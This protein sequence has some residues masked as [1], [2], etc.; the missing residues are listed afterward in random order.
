M[1]RTHTCGEIRK[2]DTG[3]DITLSGWVHRRRDHGGIIF[4]DLR[5]RY[6]LTQIV[7]DPEEN[8]DAHHV[9]ESL[10]SE[11]VIQI[12]G[13]VRP[14]LEG[15]ENSN[16]DTGEV[17]VL[18]SQVNILNKAK[19]PPFEIDQDKDVREDLRLEYRY[20]DLRKER[21]AKNLALRAGMTKTIRDFFENEDFLDIETPIMVKGTPEGSR[22]YL[23]PSRL[24]PG[25]FYV[26]PQSP[27]QLKQLLMVS[28]VDR[29]F[30]VPRCF[31]DEDQRGD[32]QPEFTQAEI[33]MSF[34][35]QEDILDV[36]ERCLVKLT[37]KH[38]AGK[39]FP[40]KFPR[41]TWQKAME[42]FGSDKPDLRFEMEFV[43][44]T[45]EAK[46]SGF[47]IFE[48][49]ENLFALPVSK[50]YGELTRKDIDELTELA[51]THGAGGLAWLRVGEES[52]PVAKNSN[53]GFLQSV[54]Q[55]T[56]AKNGDLIFFGAGDF[57]H[58][59]EPLGQVRLS[60]GDKFNLKNPEEFAYA[61]VLDFPMF[62]KNAEGQVGAVHHPFTRPHP[63][64]EAK[65]ES[66]PLHCRAVAYD[67]IM[68]GVELG[69]GSLR[70]HEPELQSKIFDILGI[71]K[72][73]AQKRFGHLLKAFE[74][75]APPH[76][77]LALGLDR[78]VMLFAEEPNIR[79]VIAFPKTN[80]HKTLCWGH[81][82]LCQ[83][84]R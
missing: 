8:A 61:W 10:R 45:E 77:G 4:I 54:Q 15:M 46:T 56:G 20:L 39:R 70:I 11:Y 9:G 36:I 14:R 6:G 42:R 55:K 31:R 84:I 62:E 82:R 43:N 40:K 17:E 64:D 34:V 22:E 35:E 3:K 69:G 67:V 30:Q 78:L 51:R 68:N 53:A 66:E 60:L 12:T 24:F 52:G 13:T 28:G 25:E 65:L 71:S 63:E 83:Q 79:E 1:L 29:Y 81:Q 7:F 80:P 21:M 2:Q 18:V 72:E 73:D 19:T 26:L 75:G 48:K 27:Q 44:M 74:Y 58:A 5:D 50:N 59:T 38:A 41:L 37:E 16:M 76:G 33:E 57:I 47:G 49:S 32:R 23:V